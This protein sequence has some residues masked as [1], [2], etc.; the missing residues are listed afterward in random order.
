MYFNLL[1]RKL[2]RMRLTLISPTF[3]LT[4][5]NISETAMGVRVEAQGNTS[6]QKLKEYVDTT[7]K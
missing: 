4:N 1:N 7:Y 6:N 5:L 3:E 2:V